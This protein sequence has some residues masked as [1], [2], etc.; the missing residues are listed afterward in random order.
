MFYTKM[1]A[2]SL[3]K[4]H[5]D[6][7]NYIIFEKEIELNK[8][9]MASIEI[10]GKRLVEK[11]DY[12]KDNPICVNEITKDIN[13]YKD[14]NGVLISDDIKKKIITEVDTKIGTHLNLLNEDQSAKKLRELL[15]Q[16]KDKINVK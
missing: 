4:K 1:L 5:C 6:S 13:S 9:I 3:R 11:L 7:R 2:V 14:S 10:I 15:K 8:R 16:I 12:L